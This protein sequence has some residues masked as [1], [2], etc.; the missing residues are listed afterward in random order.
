[1]RIGLGIF[2]ALAALG[3]V[4]DPAK[5]QL[6]TLLK[7]ADIPASWIYD[8]VNAG[9]AEAKKSAKPMLVVFR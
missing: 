3:A 5:E 9:F 1:M 8:D 2:A 6:K 7:D 4:Q